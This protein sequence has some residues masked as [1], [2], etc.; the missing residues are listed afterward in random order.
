MEKD[1]GSDFL[2]HEIQV[3][4]NGLETALK[5]H[6]EQLTHPIYMPRNEE[7]V[8]R[9]IVALSQQIRNVK[10]RPQV[11]LTF[12]ETRGTDL[13]FTVILV[14]VCTERDPSVQEL[15][16]RSKTDLKYIPDRI[17]K[18]RSIRHKYTKEATV[19]RTYLPEHLFLR[20]NHTVDLY[21][22][23]TFLF[24]KLCA[25][26]GNLRDYNGGMILKQNE[27]LTA[28]KTSLGKIA[29]TQPILVEKFFHALAPIEMRTSCAIEPLKQLF[30][31]LL[32]SVRKETPRLPFAGSDFLFKQEEDR[33]IAVIPNKRT[34]LKAIE[35][36]KIP[37]HQ[38]VSVALDIHD[39][40][41]LGLLLLSSDKDLQSAL[42]ASLRD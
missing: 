22:V 36:L 42:L 38:F 17:R 6:I 10:D 39:V 23:R 33:V 15:F 16:A 13:Y 11:I 4:K 2:L 9:N 1:D 14:R 24:D 25:I 31:M 3:L 29:Q 20:T 18:I 12:D 8:L 19:F 27:Q 28:L 41:Y 35:A 5:G 21:K 37:L 7:E 32:T 40:S 26:L 30:L 34:M